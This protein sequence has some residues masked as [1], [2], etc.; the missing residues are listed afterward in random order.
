MQRERE[1]LSD[2]EKTLHQ[3]EDTIY[4]LEEDLRESQ[5]VYSVHEWMSVSQFF[6]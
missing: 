1:S 6:V 3:K 2:L 4:K 5:E